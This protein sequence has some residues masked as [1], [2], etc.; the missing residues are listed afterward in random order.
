MV[1]QIDKNL[2]IDAAGQ[3]LGR[4]ASAAAYHLRGKTSPTFQPNRLSGHKVEIINAAKINIDEKKLIGKVYARY[5]GYPGGLRH[6]SLEQ[7]IAKHGV[8]EALRRAVR[9]MLPN[10]RL[11]PEILK[12]LTIND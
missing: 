5:S 2:T 1:T 3:S 8:G 11:R 6:E 12:N 10:N 7:V 4:V 9:R